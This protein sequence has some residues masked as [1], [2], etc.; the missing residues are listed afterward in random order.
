MNSRASVV[1]AAIP[2]A[3]VGSS[4]VVMLLRRPR[5]LRSDIAREQHEVPPI[6]LFV[7]VHIL[8]PGYG[9]CT[10]NSTTMKGKYWRH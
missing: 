2:K 4:V 3:Q 8:G 10:A 5:A 6:T 1:L 9:P 7:A